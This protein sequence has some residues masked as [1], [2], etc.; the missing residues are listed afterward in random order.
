MNIDKIRQHIESALEDFANYRT[1]SL[2]VEKNFDESFKPIFTIK[3]RDFKKDG[4]VYYSL[5]QIY[6]SYSDPTEYTFA[7]E[8]LG[9]WK[10]WQKLCN[11]KFLGALIN[12]WREEL[13]IKLRS[14]S[15]RSIIQTAKEGGHKGVTAAKYVS[16]HGWNKRKAGRPTTAEVKRETKVLSKLETE[17]NKDLE[18]LDIH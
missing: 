6:L 10:H 3:E 9:S 8:V 17:I 14:E 4:T 11:N 7:T 18:R 12:E 5:K 16:E 13:E 2:F 1:L 15:I